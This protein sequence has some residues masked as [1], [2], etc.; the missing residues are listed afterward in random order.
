MIH[1][2]FIS[3]K[4]RLERNPF[5]DYAAQKEHLKFWVNREDDL[6]EWKKVLS[7]ASHGKSNFITF[8][9]GDYGMGK[10]L[11]LFKV[12]EK[13]KEYKNFFPVLMS[14]KGEERSKKPGIDFIQRIFKSID[15]DQIKAKEKDIE[16]LQ[17]I[18]KEVRNVYERIFFGE[19]EV[20]DMAVYFLRGELKPT[21]SQMRK[22]EVLRKIDDIDIAK[23]YFKGLLYLLRLT[24][25]STIVLVI[26][27]FEYLFSLVTKSQQPI[28]LAALR[29]L[30]DLPLQLNNDKIANMAFFLA[31]SEDG[32]RRLKDL[33]KIEIATGGPVRPL[34]RRI[35]L[36]MKLAELDKEATKELIAK[37]LRYN[38]AKGKFEVDPLI[39]YTED[40]VKFIHESTAGKPGDIIKKCGHILDLGLKYRIPELNEEFAKEALQERRIE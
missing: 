2:K 17:V 11:S 32:Y 5:L 35:N 23:E 15:F 19:D 29:G 39:P 7:D 12:A 8:I 33:E 18:S 26:D 21:Q 20:K 38:R 36:E 3:E 27:E 6:E 25:F 14:F 30:Y 4:Y 10:S 1:D 16:K 37:R 40:F 31:V 9:I 28:Y 13:C 34:M 24:D 22:L